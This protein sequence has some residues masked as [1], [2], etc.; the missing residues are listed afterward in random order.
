M[1]RLASIVLA[2]AYLSTPASAGI[3]LAPLQGVTLKELIP[4]ATW[5]KQFKITDGKDRGK[6]VPLTFDRDGVREERWKL[7]FGDYAGIVMQNESGRGLVMERLDLF[8]S[9]SYV[10]YQPALPILT[11]DLAS[12][13]GGR[14]IA[15][16]KMFD[17]A[18]GKLKRT[19][20]VTHLVKKVSPARFD[21]PAG[22]I[23]GY[24]IEI[25]HRMDMPYAQ[26]QMTLG[27]GCR[28]D[29]GPVFGSGQYTITKLGVF[30]ETKTAAAA[31]T[32]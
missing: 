29:E 14:H 17:V 26:L 30:T 8:K 25:D 23:E 18:S 19:G 9:G 10:V 20:R 28:L 7:V 27:L 32:N 11:L 3:S 4:L 16:F 1:H 24:F 13:G 5:N 2:L 22:L 6:I 15:D 21:T 31:L 12:G